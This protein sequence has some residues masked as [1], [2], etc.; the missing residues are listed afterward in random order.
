MTQAMT[1]DLQKQLVVALSD[2]NARLE[3]PSYKI[4]VSANEINHNH[5]VGIFLHRLFPDT[6][7]I[8]SIRSI[9]L[10]GG[11]HYFGNQSFCL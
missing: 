4:V 7:D 1:I 10:Y 3:C 8:Y 11:D 5:G 2:L 9:D 6:S